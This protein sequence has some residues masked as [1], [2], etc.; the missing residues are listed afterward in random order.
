M[1]GQRNDHWILQSG[2]HRHRARA[3]PGALGKSLI[4]VGPTENWRRQWIGSS[5]KEFCYK[6]KEKNEA[7]VGGK[8]RKWGQK[9]AFFFLRLEK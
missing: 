1:R 5:F 9:R 2:D 8:G 6:V 4:G 3:V 7:V